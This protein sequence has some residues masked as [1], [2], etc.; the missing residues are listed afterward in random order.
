MRSELDVSLRSPDLTPGAKEALA[1]AREEVER[2]ARIVDNL[3]TLARID[4][5]GLELLRDIRSEG[6][7]RESSRMTEGRR[8]P[9]AFMVLA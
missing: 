5:G 7:Q 6:R 8:G 2:M 3:L 9:D 4:E 1:S